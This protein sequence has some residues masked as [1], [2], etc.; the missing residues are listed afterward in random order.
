MW[1]RTGIFVEVG[2]NR[3]SRYGH[4]DQN[5]Y[6]R[7]MVK[8]QCSA[9]CVLRDLFPDLIHKGNIDMEKNSQIY[10]R[11]MLQIDATRSFNA[12]YRRSSPHWC[13]VRPFVATG[14]KAM[15]IALYVRQHT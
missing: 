13:I 9:K 12:I 5:E 11:I 3:R 1:R 10:N 6:R 2:Q 14:R 4:N 7:V 8:R 15:E